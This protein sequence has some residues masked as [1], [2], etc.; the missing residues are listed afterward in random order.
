[1]YSISLPSV[2]SPGRDVFMCSSFHYNF[3]A[4][5]TLMRSNWTSKGVG[6]S[7]SVGRALNLAFDVVAFAEESEPVVQYFL[8]LVGQV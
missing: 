3:T 1:M 5:P 7:I 2:V 8:V 6:N 4:L